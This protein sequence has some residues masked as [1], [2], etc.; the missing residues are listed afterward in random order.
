MKASDKGII[1]GVLMALVLVGFYVKVLS[2]K[3]EKAS[4]LKD[5]IS[6]LQSDIDVAEQNAAYGEEA[7]QD[8]PT[9]YGRMVVLGKA[10]PEQADTASLLVELNSISSKSN[11]EFN[12]LQLAQD[13]SSSS[14]GATA[15]TS[16]SSST[17]T[18]TT[19]TSTTST[20]PSASGA[21]SSTAPTTSPTAAPATEASAANV[22]LGAAVGPGGLSTLP[23]TLS[24]EGSFF[25]VTSF[26]AGLDSL[27][28]VR[29][30]GATVAAD[31]R[32]M[33]VDGFSLSLTDQTA[34]GSPPLNV[35]LAVTTY[36][37]P[38][39][40]GLTAGATPGGPAPSV[41]APETQTTSATVAP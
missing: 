34:G 5:E 19:P 28:H 27:N 1:L 2:P 10:V 8:F 35:N 4:Q 31:G 30:G 26:F 32:L 13:G 12:A 33:T 39:T 36:V 3:R 21:S 22:P 16:G 17:G 20:T 11:V 25:D 24:F 7:R 41:T 29:D 9:Y 6:K 23:Y 14:A 40:Q 18:S 38:G 37:T 15:T